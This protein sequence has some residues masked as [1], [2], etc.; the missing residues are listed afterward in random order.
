MGGDA[1]LGMTPTV[2]G[3]LLR[4]EGRPPQW[5]GACEEVEAMAQGFQ[6]GEKPPPKWGVLCEWIAL[7]RWPR[8]LSEKPPPKWGV[9]CES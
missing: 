5:G 2:W 7:P 9:L 8:C 6:E 3:W 1:V 4:L